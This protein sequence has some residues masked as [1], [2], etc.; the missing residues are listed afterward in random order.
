MLPAIWLI[1]VDLQAGR[2]LPVT[3][4]THAVRFSRCAPYR[5]DANGKH[6]HQPAHRF[7]DRR[8]SVPA[9]RATTDRWLASLNNVPPTLRANDITMA[10]ESFEVPRRSAG[11]GKLYLEGAVQQR[12]SDR[13]AQNVNADGNALYGALSF[14]AGPTVFDAG[15]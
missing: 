8:P 1:G 4:S 14:D 10:G 7:I 3:L 11:H 6:R 13:A 12:S 9:T 5:Y 15:D 2:G